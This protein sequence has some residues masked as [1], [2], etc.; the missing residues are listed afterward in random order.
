MYVC[1]FFNPQKKSQC[2]HSVNTGE[3]SNYQIEVTASLSF[4]MG[5]TKRK[6]ISVSFLYGS[7][8][9][10]SSALAPPKLEVRRSRRFRTH[11]ATFAP[12]LSSCLSASDDQVVPGSPINEQP[13]SKNDQHVPG[14]PISY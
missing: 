5:S 4:N 10:A 11:H 12:S 3:S 8:D 13:L 1:F 14:S 9:R 7:D 2:V 6:E